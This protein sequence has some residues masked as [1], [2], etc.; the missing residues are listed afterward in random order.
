MLIAC[1][2]VCFG[3]SKSGRKCTLLMLEDLELSDVFYKDGRTLQPLNQQKNVRSLP[4]FLKPTEQNFDLLIV[5]PKAGEP[6]QPSHILVGRAPLVGKPKAVMLL[7]AKNPEGDLPLK[8]GVLDDTLRGF[9]VSTVRYAN[10][11]SQP[12]YVKI[13]EKVTKLKQ[14]VFTDIKVKAEEGGGYLYATYADQ[15]ARKLDHKRMYMHS[16]A[17]KIIVLTDP[18]RKGRKLG[19]TFIPQNISPEQLAAAGGA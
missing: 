12:L 17:R 18:T 19:Y 11:S 6:D 16:R 13:G 2:C 10:F 3:Q 5:N 8:I 4:F 7:V 14:G 9:P 15:K 1:L